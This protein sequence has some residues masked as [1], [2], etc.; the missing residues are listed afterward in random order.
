MGMTK[1]EAVN[2]MLNSINE[3]N[4]SMG[5]QAGLNA[6]DLEKQ[7]EQSQASL[8]FMMSNIYDK[9]KEGGVIA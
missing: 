8:V 9:L 7:I 1:D 2:I 4:R 3:D 6:A 5:I